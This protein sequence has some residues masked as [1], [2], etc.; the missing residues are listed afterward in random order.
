M[1]SVTIKDGTALKRIISLL[2]AIALMFA[3][4]PMSFAAFDPETTELSM[5]YAILMEAESGS[6]LFEKN[7]SDEAYP[8]ST[9]KMM[10]L[11]LALENE[12]LDKQV[13]IPSCAA[14][15]PSDSSLVPV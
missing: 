6:V 4:A 2:L 11:L 14:D 15:V 9:T 3:F 13:T 12:E 8:A 7:C 10:T 1:L 5:K